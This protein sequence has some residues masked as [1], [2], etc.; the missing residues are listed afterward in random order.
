MRFLMYPHRSIED[1]T[2]DIV[3][4]QAVAQGG[5]DNEITSSCVE[6]S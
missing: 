5:A 1:S 3:A 6:L 4:S 2:C